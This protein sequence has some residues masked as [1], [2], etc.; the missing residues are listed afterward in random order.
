MPEQLVSLADGVVGGSGYYER[1]RHE[2]KNKKLRIRNEKVKQ[3]P[4]YFFNL[5]S[6]LRAVS[7]LLIKIAI[8]S[9][10]S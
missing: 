2:M 4:S 1:N 3:M 5:S 10:H 8:N 7:I 9:L 6:L